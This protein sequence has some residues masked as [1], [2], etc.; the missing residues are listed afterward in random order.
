MGLSL[1]VGAGG[2]VGRALVEFLMTQTKD[3]VRTASRGQMVASSFVG[4]V[5]FNLPLDFRSLT[6]QDYSRMLAGVETVYFMAAATPQALAHLNKSH[7][8]KA[9]EDNAQM[10][11]GF[12]SACF[13]HGVRRF[14]FVSSCGVH[15][16]KSGDTAFTELSPLVLHN[17]YVISKI[18]AEK[19][20]LNSSSPLPELTIVRPPMVYGPGFKGPMRHL[21]HFIKRGIPLPLASV[22]QNRRSMIGVSNLVHFL[23]H[24]AQHREAAG[25]VFVV[26]DDERPS[27]TAFLRLAGVAANRKALLFPA[28]QPVMDIAS[29]VLGVHSKFQRLFG[30]YDVDD[31]KCRTLLGWKPPVS[32]MA[33]LQNIFS[34]SE[35][36]SGKSAVN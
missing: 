5:Q 27:T 11:L 24:A 17:E 26:A 1:V 35:S 13:D 29:K 3:G 15:G 6:L 34:Q 33:E 8:D 20:L 2:F 9:L 23:H 31:G 22:T 10:P 21:L 30:N 25:Q 28:P 7:R 14:V 36:N 16:D 18:E 12:A 19:L 4:Q 32:M